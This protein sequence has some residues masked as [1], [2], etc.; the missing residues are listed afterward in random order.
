[1]CGT[2]GNGQTPPPLARPRPE[3]AALYYPASLCTC[4]AMPGAH[5]PYAAMHVLRHA[6]Y[7]R[8]VCCSPLRYAHSVCCLLAAVR[9]ACGTELARGGSQQQGS[10]SQ[11]RKNQGMGGARSYRPT[12][13]IREVRY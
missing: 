9:H 10:Q 1:M 6:R 5:I 12:G 13:C 7:S 4:Y 3:M 2:P 11:S 8:T